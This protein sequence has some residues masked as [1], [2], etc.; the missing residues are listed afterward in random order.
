MAAVLGNIHTAVSTDYFGTPIEDIPLIQEIGVP[1]NFALVAYLTT[2]GGIAEGWVYQAYSAYALPLLGGF[3][4][5]MTP[6][7][8]P[9]YDTRQLLG[10]LDGLKGA[11]DMEFLVGVPGDAIRSSDILSFTQTMVLIFIIIGNISYFGAKM[12]RREGE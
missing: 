1:S 9:Y 8:K 11:A 4:S 10:I 12:T 7:L 3:L 2:S 6:S 5:M